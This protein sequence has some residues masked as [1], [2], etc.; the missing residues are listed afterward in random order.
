MKCYLFIDRYKMGRLDLTKMCEWSVSY[1]HR[2][3]KAT[4]SWRSVL[5]TCDFFQRSHRLE[6]LRST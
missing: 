3:K 2:M 5:K 1:S 4:F 6:E